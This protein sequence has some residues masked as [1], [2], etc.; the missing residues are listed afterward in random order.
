MHAC[1]LAVHKKD[2][3]PFSSLPTLLL[4]CEGHTYSTYV[5]PPSPPFLSLC[6]VFKIT[7]CSSHKIAW[8]GLC[9][10]SALPFL[11]DFQSHGWCGP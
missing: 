11:I 9:R 10:H 2:I 1:W 4:C 5:T 3:P 6:D 8:H 7:H